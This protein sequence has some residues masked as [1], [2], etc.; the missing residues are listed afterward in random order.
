MNALR[1]RVNLIG[2]LGAEPEVVT[3][4]SGRTLARFPLATNEGYKNKDGEWK[5]NTQWHSITAWGKTGELAA[6]MLNKGQEVALE[7]RIV[8]KSY[9]S[10]EGEKRYGTTIELNEFLIISLK[11]QDAK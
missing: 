9:E 10:K 8:N 11:N 5:E 4:D 2:R 7:G 6:K 1:N 3:F